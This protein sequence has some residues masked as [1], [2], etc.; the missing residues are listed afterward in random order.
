V[1]DPDVTDTIIRPR[2][3][4]S[5][6]ATGER[7][8]AHADASAPP[9][10]AAT[11][12]YRL[13]VGADDPV[14]LE[15]PVLVGRDPRAPRVA[16]GARPRLI[17]VPSSRRVVSGTHVE[18]R[19]HGVTVVVTDLHSTN[20]TVVVVPGAAPVRLHPGDSLVVAPGAE[21]ELGDGVRLAVLPVDPAPAAS[22]A[23]EVG[24]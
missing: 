4:E 22:V 11:S 21:I 13:R 9:A 19:Q 6:S 23:A 17:S 3:A 8:A 5:A 18:V 14:P 10:P 7:H 12:V 20:G 1:D 2:R 15:V 16:T 24:R